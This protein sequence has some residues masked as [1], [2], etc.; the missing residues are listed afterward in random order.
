[1]TEAAPTLALEAT[2]AL[3]PR[4]TR[5][6]TEQEQ[7]I[8]MLRTEGGATIDEMVAVTNWAVHCADV[9]ISRIP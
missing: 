7:L 9:G 4:K 5:E 6:G 2:D 1:M 8:A 3:K